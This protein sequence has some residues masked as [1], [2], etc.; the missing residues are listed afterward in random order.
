MY[1]FPRKTKSVT[2]VTPAMKALKRVS[3]VVLAK[4]SIKA[5]GN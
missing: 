1:Y 4:N 3:S 5:L 2:T